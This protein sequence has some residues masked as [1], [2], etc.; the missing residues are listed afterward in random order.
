MKSVT[1]TIGPSALARASVTYGVRGGSEGWSRFQR[2]TDEGVLPQRLVA[3][4]R[5]TARRRHRGPRPAA[6]CASQGGLAGRPGEQDGR[7]PRRALRGRGKAVQ[8]PHDALVHALGL[9]RHRVVLVVKGQVVEDVLAAALARTSGVMPSRTMVG[10][11]V[12]ESRV[13]GLHVGDGRGQQ[14]RLAV[15][16]LQPFAE[17]GGPPGR[18]RPAESPGPRMSAEG[19]DQVADPLEPEHRIEDE[20]R[21]HGLAPGGVSRPGR[22]EVGH[23]RRP[24][25]IPSSRIWPSLASE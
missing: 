18:G 21:D 19:P 14:E 17:Q 2:S 22:G 25:L 10:H 5:S 1:A 24:R 13:V 12:G 16:V 7:P 4:R 23:A 20:K 11:L 3:G 6:R 9:G 15:V 8:A